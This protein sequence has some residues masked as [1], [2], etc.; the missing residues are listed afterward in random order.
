MPLR[1]TQGMSDLLAPV[2]CEMEDEVATFWCFVGLMQRT[3]FVATP[4]DRDMDLNL[5]YL[6][7]LVR[8]MVPKFHEHIQKQKDASEM[9]FCHRWILL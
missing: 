2:L 1:Y 5:K 6:K 4:T 9:L 3:T 8:I 7:E